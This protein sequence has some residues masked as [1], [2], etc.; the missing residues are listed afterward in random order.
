M[1]SASKAFDEIGDK[2]EHQIYVININ[3]TTILVV[4]AASLIIKA[5]DTKINKKY[6]TRVKAIFTPMNNAQHVLQKASASKT[7]NA[8]PNLPSSDKIP[9]PHIGQKWPFADIASSASSSCGGSNVKSSTRGIPISIRSEFVIELFI[10]FADITSSASSSCGRSNVK[11]LT[12]GIPI[13]IRSE[14][15]I[16]LLIVNVVIFKEIGGE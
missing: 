16:E 15:A 5:S 4:T 1:F 8:I 11:S 9:N 12:R 14:F 2:F 3:I 10:I 7:K 13:S 6:S